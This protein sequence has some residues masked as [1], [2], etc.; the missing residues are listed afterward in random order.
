M[1]HRRRQFGS[2]AHE[3]FGKYQRLLANIDERSMQGL[4][5]LGEKRCDRAISDLAACEH[6]LGELHAHRDSTGDP[7][8]YFQEI[9]N[10]E[11]AV[12]DLNVVVQQSCRFTPTTKRR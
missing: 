6:M 9:S 1:R 10:A 12:G 7:E 2:P 5:A 8:R 11:V 4:K 3:H